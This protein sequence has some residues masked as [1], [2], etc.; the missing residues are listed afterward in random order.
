MKFQDIRIKIQQTKSILKIVIEVVI[1]LQVIFYFFMFYKINYKIYAAIKTLINEHYP[2]KQINWGLVLK[3]LNFKSPLLYSL[4]VDLLLVP[5]VYLVL[6]NSSGDPVNENKNEKIIRGSTVESVK[7][8]KKTVDYNDVFCTIGDVPLTIKIIYRNILVLGATGS[9]KTQII[10][11]ILFDSYNRFD[12]NGIIYDSKKDSVP[13]FYNPK[14]DIIFNPADDRCPAWNIL[15]EVEDK[16]DAATLAE[17]LVPEPEASNPNGFFITNARHIL[18]AMILY[19]KMKGLG[20]NE[21]LIKIASKTPEDLLK[22]FK[23]D[24]EVEK[25]CIM[26]IT[27]LQSE[28]VRSMMTEISRYLKAFTIMPS[29]P[30]KEGMKTFNI[31]KDFLKKRKIRIF[32]NL[33]KNSEIFVKPIMKIFMELLIKK[34]LSAPD[35]EN[36]PT[37]FLF[38]ELSNFDKTPSIMD[39]LDKGRSKN[40][41]VIVGIQDKAKTEFVYGHDLTMNMMNS[42]NSAIY[43]RVNSN[44]E[45]E[46]VSRQIGSQEVE[47]TSESDSVTDEKYTHSKSTQIV[48]KKLFLPSQILKWQDL[49]AVVKLVNIPYFMHINLVY[50]AY[51][52]INEGLISSNRLFIPKSENKQNSE[53][54]QAVSYADGEITDKNQIVK[55]DLIEEAK[56]AS[57]EKKQEEPEKHI[58]RK[59]KGI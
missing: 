17:V 49:E 58:E 15:D 45:A 6:K 42:C 27:P 18:E 28:E 57:I 23:S 25:Q 11:K 47:R 50:Q 34:F 2:L 16:A 26:A 24:P 44:D 43:L 37:L 14:Y 5:A 55:N 13:V 36:T 52:K 59:L 40:A 38:D 51:T 30:D 56:P 29:K 22:L 32:F 46:Y 7:K 54:Q 33:D 3:D 4:L 35:G 31:T 19:L 12:Y 53:N 41:S 39:L 9:G 8:Y 48:E 1:A 10:L 20:T 21:N